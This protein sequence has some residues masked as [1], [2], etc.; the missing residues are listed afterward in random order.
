MV[1]RSFA[2]VRAAVEKI[3]RENPEAKRVATK[4]DD[5]S[6]TAG[7]GFV[8]FD[9]EEIRAEGARAESEF[10]K[11]QGQ[12]HDEKV[13][14]GVIV[15]EWRTDVIARLSPS[16]QGFV[17]D[18]GYKARS[19][20]VQILLGEHGT[21]YQGA[22]YP[23]P[24]SVHAQIDAIVRRVA[25]YYH[26]QGFRGSMGVDFIVLTNGQVMPTEVNARRLGTTHP[27]TAVKWLTGAKRDSADGRLK[28]A[29]GTPIYSVNQWLRAEGDQ[30]ASLSQEQFFDRLAQA[31]L[32][33][34][35]ERRSGI[36]PQITSGLAQN[37]VELTAVATSAAAAKELQQ[38]ARAL[39]V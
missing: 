27:Y 34:N 31:G 20:H 26:A 7:D 33:W 9:L 19:T 29:D 5:A 15:E 24:D 16:G 13:S 30:L 36:I 37:F 32:L 25:M 23:A 10:A 6:Y 2:T 17:T 22:I 28:L 38:A 12:L 1:H 18:S 8:F 35:A 3:A 11:A 4:M 39:F 14:E 21:S